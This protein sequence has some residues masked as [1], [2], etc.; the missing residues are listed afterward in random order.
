MAGDPP[1]VRVGSEVTFNGS[2]Y[3]SD[4]T[5]VAYEWRSD[6]DGIFGYQKDFKFSKKFMKFQY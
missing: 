6:S 5:I 1:P 4:G 3:D 2:G